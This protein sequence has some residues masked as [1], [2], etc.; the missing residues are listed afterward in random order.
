MDSM[1]PLVTN[2]DTGTTL[3]NNCLPELN[4]SIAHCDAPRQADPL[5]C[6]TGALVT[7]RN[8]LVDLKNK[9][10]AEGSLLELL[11]VQQ[12][13][14]GQFFKIPASWGLLTRY[15]SL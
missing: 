8:A 9:G 6:R 7:L 14:K 3:Y 2:N 13:E 4:V 10:F 1:G 12:L 5:S 15:L 11:N